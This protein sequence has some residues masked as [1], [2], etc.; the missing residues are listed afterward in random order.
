MGL[1]V[2]SKCLKYNF[3]ESR[4][5]TRVTRL[6]Q[7]FIL[8]IWVEEVDLVELTHREAIIARLLVTARRALT[9]KSRLPRNCFG[10]LPTHVG[11]LLNDPS[12]RSCT[13]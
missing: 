10:S 11:V 7:Y 3:K 8:E 9:A 5:W 1:F 12:G 4:K 6:V 2:K 13:F